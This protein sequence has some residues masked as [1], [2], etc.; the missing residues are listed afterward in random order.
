MQSETLYTD[1]RIAPA[2]HQHP[3]AWPNLSRR[4][5]MP[6][7]TPEKTCTK[8]G[9]PYPATTEYFHK[10]NSYADGL[11]RECK[12]C[13]NEL[14][15]KYRIANI[16][17]T[18]AATNTWNK[19]HKEIMRAVQS[20]WRTNH[21]EEH[22]RK[23]LEWKKNNPEK[24]KAIARAGWQNRRAKEKQAVGRHTKEEIATLYKSQNGKCWYCLIDISKYFEVDHRI[25]ISRGGSNDVGNLC[26]TCQKCNQ[27]KGA[28]LVH[29]WN[30]R[31]F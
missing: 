24:Y 31:L 23:N 19:N 18:R 9:K 21:K 6:E 16:E 22:K 29:E 20:R 15:Y 25:P 13:I 17:K 26:L 8:C 28:K 1:I 27:S 10:N 7:Y 2:M 12:I 11:R 14:A 30:G 4:F 5:D 3:G